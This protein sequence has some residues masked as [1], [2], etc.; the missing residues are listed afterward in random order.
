MD[1]AS[2]SYWL[3]ADGYNNYTVNITSSSVLTDDE[4]SEIDDSLAYPPVIDQNIS[5]QLISGSEK[6]LI[7]GYDQNDEDN[8]TFSAVANNGNIT[9]GF[10]NNILTLTPNVNQG[11]SKVKITMNSNGDTAEKEF[12]V[13][14]SDSKYLFWKRVYRKRAV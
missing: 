8:A 5:T 13:I 10:E 4:K 9:P 14:I 7:Y 2:S 1:G 12:D 3:M 6:M 11:H